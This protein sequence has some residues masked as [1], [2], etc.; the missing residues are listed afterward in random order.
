MSD[1]PDSPRPSDQ[2]AK[3][4]NYYPPIK[5]KL[6][7][8]PF[9][10]ASVEVV[11]KVIALFLSEDK[12]VLDKLYKVTL[13][14]LD[15]HRCPLLEILALNPRTPPEILENIIRDSEGLPCRAK[16]FALANPALPRKL[17]L[18]YAARGEADVLL[19]PNI[20]E[21][22]LL[23]FL[24]SD[25]DLRALLRRKM[26]HPRVLRYFLFV[27]NNKLRRRAVLHPSMTPEVLESFIYD[28]DPVVRPAVARK[29]SELVALHIEKYFVY[30]DKGVDVRRAIFERTK[31]VEF[32]EEFYDDP[33]PALREAIAKNPLCPQWIL[34]ALA[35]DPEASVR[36][37]VAGNPN[38]PW[39]VLWNLTKD[40]DEDVRV[41]LAW[42]RKAPLHVLEKLAEDNSER[43][44]YALTWNSSVPK[45]LYDRAHDRL[46]ELRSARLRV[47]LKPTD[48]KLS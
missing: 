10:K 13:M 37:A 8:E 45:E 40:G 24:Q 6:G 17:L 14:A 41:A 29:A 11:S 34:T 46:V 30:E 16:S 31:H 25:G 39:E 42:N 3:T 19:N 7:V 12:L 20:D 28:K 5:Q 15:D 23:T 36:A 26:I 22:V 1:S 27:E 18:K 21:E 2:P 43:V 32:L 35:E 47:K 33:D 48:V 38:S 9:S 4:P 44:L